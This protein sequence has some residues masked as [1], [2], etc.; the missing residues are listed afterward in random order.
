MEQR[1]FLPGSEWLYIELYTSECL[2][3]SILSSIGCLLREMNDVT[4]FFYVR[5]N[6]PSFHL[7]L[8]FIARDSDSRNIKHLL[9]FCYKMFEKKMFYDMK[10][11]TYKRELERYSLMPYIETEKLF[12]QETRL[13]LDTFEFCPYIKPWELSVWLI[14]M[15]SDVLQLSVDIKVDMLSGVSGGLV[16][17]FRLDSDSQ[18]L[19]NNK[20]RLKNSRMCEIIEEKI[21][22]SDPQFVAIKE[23]FLHNT[24]EYFKKLASCKDDKHLVNFVS[25]LFHMANNRIFSDNN[26]MHEMVVYYWL[27]KFYKSFR[28]R[29]NHVSNL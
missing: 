19:L 15:Y 25:D 17:E 11:C 16:K 10:I 24:Y 2:A 28:V 27:N 18:R 29:V 13:I 8:R 22:E 20:F 14:N 21:L 7:R 6:L 23:T 5:Y 12:C 26:R 3:N 1:I 9:S 4:H